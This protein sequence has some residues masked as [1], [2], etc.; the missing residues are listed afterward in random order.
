MT[1]RPPDVFVLVSKEGELDV[2][3]RNPG[4]RCNTDDAKARQTIDAA[5]ADAVLAHQSAREC[6]H[7][8]L[9]EG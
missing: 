2:L 4:E 7:C 3:H 1:D 9:E 5:T 8:Y 6:E